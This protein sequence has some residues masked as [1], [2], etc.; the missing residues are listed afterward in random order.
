MSKANI[1]LEFSNPE[2]PDEGVYGNVR[3]DSHNPELHI[4][5]HLYPKDWFLVAE[6]LLLTKQHYRVKEKE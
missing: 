4:T 3:V 1:F 6:L 2:K 5:G